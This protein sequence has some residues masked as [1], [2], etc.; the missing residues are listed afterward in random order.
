M[1]IIRTKNTALIKQIITHP[2]VWGA[3]SDDGQSPDD[4]E[5]VTDDVIYWLHVEDKESL[6][7]YMLHPHNSVTFEVHTCLLP[8]AYGEKAKKAAQL[9]MEWIFRVT[10]C[11]KIITNVPE[12]N[13]LA[14]RYAKKAGLKTEGI[15]RKSFLKGGILLDQVMLGITKEEFLCQQQQ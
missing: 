12:S 7:L 5:P 3:V 15:N 13:Q 4:Y 11:R 2:S 14:L 9:C 1:K 8:I 10:P 6:G